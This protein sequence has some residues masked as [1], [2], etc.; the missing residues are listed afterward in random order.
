MGR[1]EL[2]LAGINAN[3]EICSPET[4]ALF[5]F[6]GD[7][8]KKHAGNEI[9]YTCAAFVKHNSAFAHGSAGRCA[10]QLIWEQTEAN[11]D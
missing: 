3:V 10:E 9:K 5:V 1:T 2:A 6:A 8:K 11:L 7:Q 4:P